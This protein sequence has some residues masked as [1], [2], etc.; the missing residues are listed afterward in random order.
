MREFIAEA[1]NEAVKEQDKRQACTLRL[2]NTAI[3]DRDMAVRGT[4]KEKI[5]DDEVL[6]MLKTM[7]SQR[8]DSS[9]QY[10]QAGRLDLAKQEREEM[11]II[12]SLMPT[13]LPEEEVRKAVKDVVA[14]I[15]ANSLRDMGKCINALKQRYPGQMDFC[16]ASGVVKELLQ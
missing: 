14:D 3:K 11:E 1:L 16:R 5:S 9:R 4:G 13:Q 12:R 2:I 6:A 7:I 10:E 8:E 15:G